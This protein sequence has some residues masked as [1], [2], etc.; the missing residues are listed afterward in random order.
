MLEKKLLKTEDAKSS[1]T[2]LAFQL[3]DI[4]GRGARRVRI[5]AGPPLSQLTVLGHLQRR[6]ALSTNDLAAAERVR[7][8]S[9]TA[10]VKALEKEGLVG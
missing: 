3:R 10:T 4:L 1:A 9:M 5:E 6:G 2:R 7:P 8:Q